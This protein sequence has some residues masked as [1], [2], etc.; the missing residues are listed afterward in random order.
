MRSTQ[1]SR[2]EPAPA[3]WLFG[4]V[5]QTG[6]QPV[7]RPWGGST[8]RPVWP[9]VGVGGEVERQDGMNLLSAYLCARLWAKRGPSGTLFPNGTPL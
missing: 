8:R 6:L 7:Q 1:L 4:R 3:L 2:P 5:L 9:V